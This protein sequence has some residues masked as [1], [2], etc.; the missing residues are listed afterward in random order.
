MFNVSGFDQLQKQLREASEALKNLD[1]DLCTVNF[2]PHDPA[3]IEAA[4]Q[5]VEAVIDERIEK[6][7]NNEMVVNVAKEMKL[8]Y[9]DEIIERAASAR[10]GG[11]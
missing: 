5:S 3:S 11:L 7:S 10:L 9:R 2:D 1:G 8:K 4:I 6:Y